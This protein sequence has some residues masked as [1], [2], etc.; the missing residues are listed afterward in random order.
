[1]VPIPMPNRSRS[2]HLH[3][4]CRSRPEIAAASFGGGSHESSVSFSQRATSL[5]GDAILKSPCSQITAMMTD[6]LPAE[7]FEYSF[8]LPRLDGL[9]G[10]RFWM[11]P[12]PFG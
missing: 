5:S 6:A 10:T 7:T 2:P 1:M 11:A 9:F 8:R 4:Y 12:S 3:R